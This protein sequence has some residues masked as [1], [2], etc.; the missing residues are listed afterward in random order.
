[1]EA[2][3]RDYS[4]FPDAAVA[5]KD[6]L[7]NP[8]LEEFLA[9]PLV[10]EAE[11]Q[12]SLRRMELLAYKDEGCFANGE[13]P[14]E[15]EWLWA[16]HVVD[17]R[18]YNAYCKIRTWLGP[19]KQW[20]YLLLPIADL[21]NFR[22]N[23]VNTEWPYQVW[24]DY[25]DGDFSVTAARDVKAGEELY[26]FYQ[27][28]SNLELVKFWGFWDPENPH[29]PEPLPTSVCSDL[30]GAVKKYLE[31]DG[32]CKAGATPARCS[33]ARITWEQCSYTREGLWGLGVM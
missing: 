15:D 8:E 18:A 28:V 4:F 29:K 5:N 27:D 33:I 25:P 32:T 12:D 17:T 16:N 22:M 13:V 19:A 9:H 20:C 14:S 2:L 31:E 1:M 11:S 6:E 7:G 10:A 30:G 23:L 26:E 21:A 24:L 3:P